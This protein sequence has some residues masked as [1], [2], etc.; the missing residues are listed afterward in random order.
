MLE[1][2]IYRLTNWGALDVS[3]GSKGLLIHLKGS[4]EIRCI[5]PYLIRP[6]AKTLV[7]PNGAN[8]LLR[9]T[10]GLRKFGLHEYGFTLLAECMVVS[11]EH[12][13]LVEGGGNKS[14]IRSKCKTWLHLIWI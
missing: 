7:P 3:A 1:F 13:E 4:F 2:G 11:S 12:G 5:I 6:V 14:A 10:N 8:V 9:L